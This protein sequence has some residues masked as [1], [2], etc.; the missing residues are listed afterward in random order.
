MCFIATSL[1]ADRT[2]T[3]A[4]CSTARIGSAAV[5]GTQIIEYLFINIDTA[6]SMTIQSGTTT[7]YNTYVLG[8]LQQVHATCYTGGS[9]QLY[10]ESNYGGDIYDA[11]NT[12]RRT[13]CPAGCNTAQPYRSD[14]LGTFS[15]YMAP[16]SITCSSS[17]HTAAAGTIS[18]GTA[19]T[20]AACTDSAA[21]CTT[22]NALGSDTA[23][24]YAIAGTLANV[25]VR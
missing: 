7:S 5:S 19:D 8:P 24:T 4:G 6:E 18:I 13:V 20:V 11:A 17:A 22:D 23:F 16:S 3:I 21:T 15:V 1:S 25:C 10:F 2:Y 9:D 12:A 14:T